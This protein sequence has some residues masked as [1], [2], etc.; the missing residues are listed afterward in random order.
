MI[1]GGELDRTGTIEPGSSRDFVIGFTLGP[2][3]T[4][5]S[6]ACILKVDLR[7][8][9]S[10]VAE[11]RTPVIFLVREPEVPLDL[12]WTFVLHHPITFAP[13]GVFTDPSLEVALEAGAGSTARSD[14]CSR[15]RPTPS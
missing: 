5:T 11:L 13:D 10:S 14:R 2:G 7:S 3:S 8:G 15:S 1:D 6:P 4:R 12:S 9:T